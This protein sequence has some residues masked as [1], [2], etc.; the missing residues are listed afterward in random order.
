[1]GK[2]LF[3]INAEVEEIKIRKQNCCW[4]RRSAKENLEADEHCRLELAVTLFVSCWS[5]SRGS[6]AIA[7]A[8]PLHSAEGRRRESEAIESSSLAVALRVAVRLKSAMEWSSRVGSRLRQGTSGGPDGPGGSVSEESASSFRLRVESTAGLDGWRGCPHTCSE[9]PFP[10]SR[11]CEG[12]ARQHQVSPKLVVT[13]VVV[14]VVAVVVAVAVAVAVAGGDVTPARPSGRA[15]PSSAQVSEKAA[16]GGASERARRLFGAR[17]VRG[18]ARRCPAANTTGST[19]PPW[20]RLAGQVK[21]ALA[22]TWFRPDRE[23]TC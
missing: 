9:S 15:A 14:V 4:H 11:R 16:R 1:V 5:R 6:V 3:K 8:S 10:H 12:G 19:R 17:G 18:R 13:L 23:D 21:L 20:L 22:T 7:V 2:Y